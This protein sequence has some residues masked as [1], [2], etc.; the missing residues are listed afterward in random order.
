[1]S[2]ATTLS[3]RSQGMILL[4]II[5]LASTVRQRAFFLGLVLPGYFTLVVWRLNRHRTLWHLYNIAASDVFPRRYAV[6]QHP[7]DVLR[8]GLSHN[9]AGELSSPAQL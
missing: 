3:Q 7:A 2:I 6:T 1:M 9:L 4:S 5:S 8:L